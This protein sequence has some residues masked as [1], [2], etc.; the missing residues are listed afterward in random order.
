MDDDER[1]QLHLRELLNLIHEDVLDIHTM[2]TQQQRANRLGALPVQSPGDV[3][4]GS[5]ERSPDRLTVPSLERAEEVIAEWAGVRTIH[6]SGGSTMY[7]TTG[8]IIAPR[9]GGKL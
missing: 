1:D 5:K 6:D 4:I 8:V 9:T 2:L 3:G 7:D